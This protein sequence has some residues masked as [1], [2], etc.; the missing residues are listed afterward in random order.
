MSN[1]C[2]KFFQLPSASRRFV[3]R[4]ILILPIAYAGLKLFG[5]N[6]LLPRIQRLS[7]DARELPESSL[8]EIQTYARLFS[9]VARRCPLPLQ[10][11]GRSVALCWLLR[12]QGIDA[13][14]HI[15]VRKENEALDA[16]AWVQF[17]DF[18]INDT[19]NVAE[20]YTRVLTSYS[21]IDTAR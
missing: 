3:L 17:G 5:L 12:Q 19:E 1:A 8:Q 9:A 11:L 2:H 18:V 15:G 14:V 10:C 4:T 21:E 16:H 13:T 7:P 20:R 6:R